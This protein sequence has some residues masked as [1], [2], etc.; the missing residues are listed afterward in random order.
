MKIPDETLLDTLRLGAKCTDDL[1]SIATDYHGQAVGIEYLLT[2]DIARAFV[3]KQFDVRVECQIKSLIHASS[4]ADQENRE[5]LRKKLGKKRIDI[6]LMHGDLVP[7]ALI[8]VKVDVSKLRKVRH[9]LKR[10]CS[11]ISKMNDAISGSIV[12]VSVFQVHIA[13][14]RHRYLRAHFVEALEKLESGLQSDLQSHGRTDPDFDFKLHP[15]QRPGEGIH[16]RE[17]LVEGEG[18]AEWETP[19]R[20]GFVARSYAILVK[21]RRTPQPR[22]LRR[23][24][25]SV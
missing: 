12:G 24:Q 18:E 7:S 23:P 22:G 11:A 20:D 5:A 1:M 17:I 15:L 16:D 3:R 25:R 13:A 19:G 2:A 8:E 10:L 9:D 14:K 4:V 21:S 6:A